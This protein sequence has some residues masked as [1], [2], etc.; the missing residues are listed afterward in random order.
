MLDFGKVVLVIFIVIR[1][2]IAAGLC[3]LIVAEARRFGKRSKK[4]KK[5]GE[6]NEDANGKGSDD[7]YGSRG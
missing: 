3:Y 4:R 6:A 5:D 1:V 2:L 7:S